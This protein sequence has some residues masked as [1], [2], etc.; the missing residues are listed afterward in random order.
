MIKLA[1]TAGLAA[2]AAYWIATEARK[3]GLVSTTA[4]QF[5]IAGAAGGLVG[6]F[7]ALK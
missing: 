1:L 4:A 5:F 2:L 7:L 3:R 6:K